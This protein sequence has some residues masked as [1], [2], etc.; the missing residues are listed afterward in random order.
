MKKYFAL[1]LAL[2][3][4]VV[5]AACGSG[6]VS[7][8]DTA[9]TPEPVVEATP[10]PTAFEPD[11][12]ILEKLGSPVILNIRNITETYPAPDDSERVILTYGFDDVDVYLESNPA[13][14]DAI[15]Q[16][17]TMEDEIYYSGTGNGDGINAV[18]EIA[19]DNYALIQ[20][21]DAGLNMEFSCMRSAYIDRA[22][23]RV[24]ALRYRINSY[25][26]G[27]HGLYV[28]RA[29]VFDTA[30][31]R[32]LSF[33]DLS[34]DR[35]ALEKLLLE[36][37]YDTL[38]NDVR[39]KPIFD[40]MTAFKSDENLDEELTALFR[41]GSWTLTEEGLSV[42]SDIYEIG[43]YADGIVRFTVS[44]EEL[45]GLLKEEW[46]PLER[47]AGGELQI[48]D[49]DDHSGKAVHLLDK[50]SISDEGSD[51]RVFADG[52]VYDVSISS[53]TYISDDIGFYQTETH[54]FCSYLSNIGVQIQTV[55]PEG[56]PD[57]MIRYRDENGE[58]H[59]FLVTESG[60][61]GSVL[62]L[63]EDS[64]AAVG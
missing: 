54:W 17:L 6:E 2:C 24:I 45:N 64:V 21:H 62:L 37:M 61:D 39:Y 51:F 30:T 33:D 9:E 38:H 58:N 13:A 44:Y 3:L 47:E 1:L 11:P 22:D 18:L 43:S 55:I 26:G 4:T 52:T 32:A 42:F 28:D 31:G 36:K 48:M 16:V 7:V 23:S 15:N 41:E 46:L 57:L 59:N 25:T 12:V 34:N 35:A 40:Y 14:A 50:V 10:E 63:E 29:F 8:H 60:E 27:A 20:D 56:M 19:M 49:I 53:V 5:M